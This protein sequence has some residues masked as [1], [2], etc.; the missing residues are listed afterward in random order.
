MSEFTDLKST[1]W[2]AANTLRGSAVDR[3][4]WKGYILPLLF[5]K[6]ISD[7]WDEETAEAAELYGDADP[8]H[9]EEIH[10]FQWRRSCDFITTRRPRTTS[11]K[12]SWRRSAP[13]S[14]P[15][16]TTARSARPGEQTD[17]NCSNSFNNSGGETP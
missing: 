6:R 2:D 14:R 9:F 5:F 4:D 8:S 17:R 16:N 12:N 7:C 15:G 1:L 10:R 13:T 11:T 3:T